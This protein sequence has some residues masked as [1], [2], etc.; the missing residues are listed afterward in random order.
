MLFYFRFNQKSNWKSQARSDRLFKINVLIK[1]CGIYSLVVNSIND[2]EISDDANQ[3]LRKVSLHKWY[4]CLVCFGNYTKLNYFYVFKYKQNKNLKLNTDD[5]SW[6]GSSYSTIDRI[7]LLKISSFIIF[8]WRWLLESGR[9][10]SFCVLR[11]RL[12]ESLLVGAYWSLRVHWH[13]KSV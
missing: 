9:L 10:L 1:M 6:A 4:F 11:L 5:F 7:R 2:N 3:Q 13:I 8:V 12:A